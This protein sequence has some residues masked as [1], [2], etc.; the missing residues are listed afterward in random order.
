[1]L[2]AFQS[3]REELAVKQKVETQSSTLASKPGLSSTSAA[4]LDL[5]HPRSGTNVPNED[6]D[7]D[8][9]PTLPPRLVST[10]PSSDQYVAPSEGHPE[11]V[12]YSHKKQSH[13]QPV[14]PSSASDQL[15]EDS[16]EPRIPSS[17]SKKHSDK[18]KH[19]S[20]SRYVS[21]SSEEDHSPVARHRS[22]KP[23]RAQPS[24]VA[25]DQDLPQ[26]DPDPLRK[27]IPSGVFCL[28]LT[29]GNLCPG[30]PPQCWVWMMKKAVKSSDLEVPPLFFH[31]AQLS[32]TPLINSNMTLRLP[33]YLREN[34]S[35]LLPQLPSG[36]R[37]D[38]QLFRTK[39]RS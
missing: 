27:W 7:V 36:T 28:S 16:D 13:K 35:S 21:F 14:D 8:Y 11:E 19:K 26:H 3:L 6:M 30:L 22:S 23:S 38:N 37:W 34:M 25:S 18:S 33:T 5:P 9:G 32:R 4:P 1:M 12:S 17:R 24:G 2:E 31:L 10:Q 29:P 15:N 39:F 20:R